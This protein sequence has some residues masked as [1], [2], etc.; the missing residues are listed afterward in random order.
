MR[1]VH[2][3]WRAL[4]HH[5]RRSLFEGATLMAARQARGLPN[6]IPADS[7]IVVAGVLR[8]PTGLGEAARGTIRA[9]QAEGRDV[10]IIDLTDVFRQEIVMAAPDL[11]APA[12][13][14]GTIIVFANPPMSS[15][16]L[17]FI[18]GEVLEGKLRIASW[19]WEY[20]RVPERWRRHITRYHRIATP[21]S[22]VHTAVRATT[23]ADSLHLPYHV[24]PLPAEPVARDRPNR[25]R[26]GFIG[27]LVAAAGRKNPGAVIE[28]AGA[29]FGAAEDVEIHMILRGASSGHPV[30]TA[31]RERARHYGL[32]LTIDQR[33]LDT[34]GH[35]ARLRTFDAFCSLHRCEG[36]G[37]N[38]AEAMAA[39]IPTV[40]TRCPAVADYLDETVGYPVAG[41]PVLAAPLIDD[42]NPGTWLEPNIAMATAALRA[43]RDNPA[44]A[45]RRAEAAVGRID[46]LYSAKAFVNALDALQTNA[47]R[48]D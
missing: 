27:D 7:Q 29:A 36:F 28:A 6:A 30:V 21:T 13:G 12:R 35:W 25:F 14:P 31:L 11:P 23:G 15:Y 20:A 40:A 2:R 5:F 39:G 18:P 19:V 24:A 46:Q 33:V 4:P 3:L 47:L 41:V 17:R 22:L 34:A 1:L 9:L 43:I 38:I 8:A 32:N 42:P 26:L 45:R 37:L 10:R 44:E 16:A 48:Q